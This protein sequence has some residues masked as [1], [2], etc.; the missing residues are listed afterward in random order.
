MDKTSTELEVGTADAARANDLGLRTAVVANLGDSYL[1][2]CV[3]TGRQ[4]VLAA[5]QVVAK[6]ES[7]LTIAWKILRQVPASR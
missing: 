2:R 7:A 4:D 3:Q 6:D 1:V 5:F